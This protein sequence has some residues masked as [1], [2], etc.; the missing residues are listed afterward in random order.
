MAGKV[1][2]LGV[3]GTPWVLG[4][5]ETRVKARRAIRWQDS[6]QGTWAIA[7]RVGPDTF[8]LDNGSR[9]IAQRGPHAAEAFEAFK[10]EWRA[11]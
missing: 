7:S 3:D 1:Y 6:P 4:D 2:V 11:R 10:A 9:L 8:I 5:Y